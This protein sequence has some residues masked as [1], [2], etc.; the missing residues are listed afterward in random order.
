MN[1]PTDSVKRKRTSR[2][3][4]QC[5]GRKA[6]CDGN[7]RCKSCADPQ[8]SQ[9]EFT[10]ASLDSRYQ[11]GLHEIAH[12][13]HLTEKERA[14]RQRTFV[15]LR[16]FDSYVTS[17]LGF[18]RTIRINSSTSNPT[19]APHIA[20]SKML[21]ASNAN[22]ELLDI[23]CNTRDSFYFGTAATPGQSSNSISA[24]QLHDLNTALDRWALKHRSLT[25]AIPGT[26]P[27][28][29]KTSLFLRFSHCYVL[30]I[31][32]C[33]FLHHIT[34]PLDQRTSSANTAVSKCVEAA[35]ETVSIAKTLEIKRMLYE[36]YAFAVDVVAMAA[37]S[38]L[39]VEL[40]APDDALAITAASSSRKAKVLLEVLALRSCSA[41]QCL[42]S[43]TV[44]YF[45]IP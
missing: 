28:S 18:P 37:I 45:Q 17:S 5:R 26:P 9:T 32:Y 31:S 20:G 3:C 13:S 40:G 24:T 43:L 33:P 21:E 14:V 2:A 35:I 8:L 41:A 34:K 1:H 27:S 30:L 25:R 12:A 4:N 36:G 42:T 44:S 16:I 10:D 11:L 19:D 29:D 23:L 7:D 15:T 39:V 38:L 22:M 6:R